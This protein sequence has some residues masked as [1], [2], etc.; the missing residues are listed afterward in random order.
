MRIKIEAYLIFE[1][2]KLP[3]FVVA[4]A[5]Q[6]DIFQ[7]FHRHYALKTNLIQM[8]NGAMKLTDINNAEANNTSK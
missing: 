6:D 2:E 7:I 4:L 1:H 3:E 5:I 8:V